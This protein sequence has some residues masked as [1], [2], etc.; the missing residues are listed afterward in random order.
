M[1]NVLIPAEF[2]EDYLKCYF[3]ITM[4][5]IPPYIWSPLSSKQFQ[6]NIH[7]APGSAVLY[8][9]A[10]VD[11]VRGV[12][13]EF[14][15]PRP[16]ACEGIA[17]QENVSKN[18]VEKI[19]EKCNIFTKNSKIGQIL[20]FPKISDRILKELKENFQNVG[21]FPQLWTNLQKIVNDFDKF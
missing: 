10:Y 2:W 6:D 8:Q 14:F 17:A 21:K 11:T 7:I 20:D 15:G 18:F 1:T 3:R 12:F 5:P 4:L 16:K 9:R 19:I 13:G